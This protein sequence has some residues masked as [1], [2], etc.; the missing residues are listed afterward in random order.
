MGK[1]HCT[2][3]TTLSILGFSNIFHAHASSNE[4]KPVS[5]PSQ[6]KIVKSS[7]EKTIYIAQT[8]STEQESSGTGDEMIDALQKRQEKIENLKELQKLDEKINSNR[9]SEKTLEALQEQNIDVESLDQ[10]QTIQQIVGDDL[11]SEEM[12]EALQEQ[13]IDVESLDQLQTIQQ[14]FN[15]NSPN[16]PETES[17]KLTKTL[18]F[19]MLTLGLPASI[20]L[21]VVATPFVKGISGVIISNYQ[22]KYGKPLVPEGSISLHNRSLK[23][24]TLIGN[25]AE[26]I[27]DEKFGNEE[28]LLLVRIKIN[29]SKGTEGYKELNHGV[30]LLQAAI[31][32]QKS[33]LRLEQTELR[34]RSRK[35]Q[36]FYKFVADNLTESDNDNIDREAFAQKVKQKQTEILP[37]ITT[38]EG[39]AAIDTYV[40]EINVLSK[41]QLGLKLLALF[42]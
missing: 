9:T 22:E 39:K 8:A 29:I 31:I 23:E 34:Y 19:R 38:E 32:A 15:S 14:I 33:F 17:T 3:A 24:I 7:P 28:F 11:T 12:L 25:K 41:Y 2:I 21:L 35:Q 5:I 1:L 10:L 26:K 4:L 13:N 40:K 18:A 37:L 6:N 16:A 27:N 36:E 30:E 42:K 20:L